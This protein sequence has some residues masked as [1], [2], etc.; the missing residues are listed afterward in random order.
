MDLKET[1]WEDLD[2]SKCDSDADKAKAIAV[3][4]ITC[5][6]NVANIV[7]FAFDADPVINAVLCVISAASIAYAWWKNQ[8][9]T[10]EASQAQMLLDFLKEESK[11]GKHA[12]GA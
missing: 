10:V 9:V 6:A 7:G 3:L 8:N 12:K 11:V 2:L 5:V 4:V 1:Q